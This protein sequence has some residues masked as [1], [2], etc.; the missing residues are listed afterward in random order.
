MVVNPLFRAGWH[1]DGIPLHFF[2]SSI[3]KKPK[4][5]TRSDPI[6][7]FAAGQPC[8]AQR[9]AFQTSPG[10]TFSS[11]KNALPPKPATKPLKLEEVVPDS[12]QFLGT[13]E[14]GRNIYRWLILTWKLPPPRPQASSNSQRHSFKGCLFV[15][16][17]DPLYKVDNLVGF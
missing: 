14:W 15:K 16:P 3:V 4:V 5:T 13:N 2:E 10:G 12:K 6:P 17:A 7:T 9:F 8:L 1:W 11:S